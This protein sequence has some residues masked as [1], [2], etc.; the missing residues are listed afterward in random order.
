M[1]CNI[2]L[3]VSEYAK[4]EDTL[5]D[6]SA[7]RKMKH[8]CGTESGEPVCLTGNTAS[9]P[10]SSSAAVAPTAA[11]SSSSAPPAASSSTASG[12]GSGSTHAS[13][14]AAK[15]A[16]APRFGKPHRLGQVVGGSALLTVV[17]YVIIQ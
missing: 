13:N 5:S 3:G 17:G 15:N 16:G 9:A 7:D 4:Q 11:S 6:L 10:S 14:Q 1:G 2:P 8:T 12:G